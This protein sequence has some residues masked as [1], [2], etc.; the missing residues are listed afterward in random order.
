MW[1][2][3][4]MRRLNL[5]MYLTLIRSEEQSQLQLVEREEIDDEEDLFEAID[6]RMNDFMNLFWAFCLKLFDH[7]VSSVLS[8][9][10]E[11]SL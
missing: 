3:K 4:T 9:L 11:L 7:R 10:S 5:I 1:N 6:K 8:C 2:E